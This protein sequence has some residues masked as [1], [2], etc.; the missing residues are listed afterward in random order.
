MKVFTT[1]ICLLGFLTA[2]AQT[3]DDELPLKSEEQFDLNFTF[4]HQNQSAFTVSFS[5]QNQTDIIKIKHS[6][7]QTDG[8]DYQQTISNKA[9]YDQM[10]EY[11]HDINI[12]I[13]QPVSN[14]QDPDAQLQ[15]K[16]MINIE[17]TWTMN[18]FVF[19]YNPAN[20]VAENKIL[21]FI[22]KVLEENKT[23]GCST[24]V[25]TQLST[26]IK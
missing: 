24:T 15:V 14:D 11:L 5:R 8:T 25:T 19:Q 13:F 16:G 17:R 3:N 20:D 9:A 4:Q 2:F 1:L 18:A 10:L 23:D 7:C 6:D 26:Y 22:V 12:T 21:E